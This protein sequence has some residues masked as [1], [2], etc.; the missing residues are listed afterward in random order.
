MGVVSWGSTVCAAPGESGVYSRISSSRDFIVSTV[1]DQFGSDAS[2][3][4][5]N[6]DSTSCSSTETYLLFEIKVDAY[7]G[8]VSWDLQDD[9]GVVLYSDYGFQDGEYRWYEGCLSGASFYYLNVYDDFG[10]GMGYP[11]NGESAYIGVMFGS[12]SYL[13]NPTYT[14]QLN[15][16]LYP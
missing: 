12:S 6:D 1:C 14:Y 4:E 5:Q 9:T 2:F 16:E 7:G 10:D 13:D 3:C 11:Y 15:M 8:E